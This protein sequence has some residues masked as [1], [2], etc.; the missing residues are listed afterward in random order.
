MSVLLR[1]PSGKVSA[2][3]PNSGRSFGGRLLIST[4]RFVVVMLAGALIGGGW[5]LAQKGFGREWRWEGGTPLRVERAF[6][7]ANW[8]ESTDVVYDWC[9]Q[10]KVATIAM[11]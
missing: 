11:P 6:I 10:S 7:D 2:P 4:I 5:Y 8:A 1:D 3:S 9:R